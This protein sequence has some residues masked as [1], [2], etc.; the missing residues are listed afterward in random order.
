MQGR[1]TFVI[2][3]RLSTV[4]NADKIVVLGQGQVLEAGSHDDLLRRNGHYAHLVRLQSGEDF[5]LEAAL[6]S[7]LAGQKTAPRAWATG[8]A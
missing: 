1:T 3:H 7:P 4:R 5:S 6:E 8:S 2:A